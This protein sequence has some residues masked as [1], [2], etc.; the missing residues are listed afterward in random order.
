M[1]STWFQ[2]ALE[3]GRMSRV[4]LTAFIMLLNHDREGVLLSS[5]FVPVNPRGF[6]VTVGILAKT[7]ALFLGNGALHLGGH[8]HH[9]APRR[10]LGAFRHHCAG[11]NYRS[12]SY[13]GAVQYHSG[14]PNQ[15]FVLNCASV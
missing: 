1:D 8:A 13:S 3:G 15:A 2:T 7:L 10:D 11:G 9:H 6:D 12:F 14:D 5:R 4:L